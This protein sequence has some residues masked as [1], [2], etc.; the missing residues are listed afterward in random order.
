MI[1]QRVYYV[2][3]E[4]GSGFPEGGD[5]EGELGRR[6]F[7]D[8]GEGCGNEEGRGERAHGEGR[9]FRR[10]GR[11]GGL[12]GDLR[13]FVEAHCEHEFGGRHE[14][15][16]EGRGGFEGRHHGGGRG[17]LGHGFGGHRER[18]FDAGDLKLVILKLL[19]EQPS[20]GYQLIKTMEQR[21]AGGYTPSAGVVYPTLTLLEEEGLATSS[22][23]N[24]KKVY[25]VTQ[26]G[27][28]Y[29]EENKRRL[30]QLFER[31][32]EAGRGFARGRSPELMK[33]FMNLRGAV[34]AR[35]SRDSITAEQIQKITDAINAAAKAIDEL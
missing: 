28:S 16:F 4:R 22:T 8:R 30:E 33:A 2:R 27:L 19:S 13:R 24:G 25:S 23:E 14:H 12:G 5:F 29:L 9:D 32:E 20:Y 3:S 7:A 11:H 17:W 34:V 10:M 18:L 21:L 31:L 15:G 26:E 1:E 6:G 35:V